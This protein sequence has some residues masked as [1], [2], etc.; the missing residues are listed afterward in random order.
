MAR[1]S[2]LPA[3]IFPLV[4]SRFCS[5]KGR[6]HVLQPFCRSF[7]G[8]RRVGRLASWL[9]YGRQHQLLPARP[10]VACDAPLAML[11]ANARQMVARALQRACGRSAGSHYWR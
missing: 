8:A 5:G 1:L 2:A 11:A 9:Q 10:A 4:P 7:F 6:F 3:E